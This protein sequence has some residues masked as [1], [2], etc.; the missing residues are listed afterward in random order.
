[1]TKPFLI[2]LTLLAL[3]CSGTRGEDP[4]RPLIEPLMRIVDLDVGESRTVTLANGEEVTVKLLEL[5]EQRCEMRS[6]V[7]Q[8]QVKVDVDGRA[9]RLT[10]A[11]YNLPRR[12]GRVEIDCAVTRGYTAGSSKNNVW[13]LDNDARLRLWPA[14]SPWIRPGTFGYPVNQRWFASDTQMANDPCYVNACDIPGQKNIYYHYG[15]DFG[16]VEGSVTVQAATEGIVV[17]RAGDLLPG[18]HPPQVKPRHDVVYLRDDRGWYYRYSHLKSIR[19]DAKL[20]Q[21]VRIG[22]PLGMLGKEGGSGGWSH[23]HFDIVVP[24]PSGRYGITDGY[25]FA[26]QAYRDEHR[27]LMIAVARPHLVAWVGETVTLDGSRSWHA[28]GREQL[29][30]YEWS[31]SDGKTRRGKI[32]RTRYQKPGHYTEVLKVTDGAGRFAY[33]FAVVQVFDRQAPTPVPPAIH[34]AYWPTTGIR[35]GDEIEF[36]VRSFGLRADEGE[37]VWDFGDGSPAARTR[38]DGNA[39]QHAPD[40]YAKTAHRY[41]TA[42]DYLVTVRRSNDRGETAVGKLWVQVGAAPEQARADAPW[43]QFHGPRR[44]NMSEETELLKEWPQGGPRLLWTFRECGRGYAGI[45]Q[46]EGLLFTSGDFGREEMV[47]ALDLNGKLVW[48]SPNGRSWRGPSPGARCVPAYREGV[49]YHMNPT[50]RIAAYVAKSGKELWGVDLEERF[51]AQY[52][53]WAMAES[54]VVED[55]AVLCVPGGTKGRIVALDRRTGATLWANTEIDDRAAYCSPIVVT[56]KGVRQLITLM[57]RSVVSVDVDTGRLL[58]SH[59]HET[60]YR[61]NVTRPIYHDGHVYVSSGYAAGGRLLKIASDSRSVTEVWHNIEQDNCH[62]GVLLVDGYLYG[63]GCRQ[64]KKGFVCLDWKS[65]K[66]VWTDRDVWKVSVTR[67]DGLIYCLGHLGKVSLVDASPRGA[68]VISE[69]ALPSKNKYDSLA[70]PVVVG[71]RLYLRQA[72]V[73]FAYDVRGPLTSR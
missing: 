37:E 52:G 1:M 39:K 30:R 57:Q 28:D 71:G 38:S 68:K 33:D 47:L 18:E 19:D 49:V 46:A 12:V 67:A 72:E 9:V 44:N 17:S 24:Q 54:P 34:A 6:A 59:V 55:D 23:L 64:S 10:S 26:F 60:P 8:A 32:V 13:A 7:R 53:S 20:G 65:G 45:S 29:R 35:A 58:W 5:D 50:H 61:M 16:G 69:F 2:A 3:A 27:P 73:L 48:K 31:L 15:L 36:Q 42:G 21:R 56:H 4:P 40:G 62:T 25:A 51:D 11:M 63:S 41:E 22:T 14:G 66:T 70:H 43:P